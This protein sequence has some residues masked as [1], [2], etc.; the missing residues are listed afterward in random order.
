M[1]WFG[2]GSLD[3]LVRPDRDSVSQPTAARSPHAQPARVLPGSSNETPDKSASGTPRETRAERAERRKA[4]KEAARAKRLAAR[5][6][7]AS[8]A[9]ARRDARAAKHEA[10]HEQHAAAV[11]ARREAAE[12]RR[13][14]RAAKHEAARERYAAAVQARREAAEARREAVRQKREM[15]RAHREPA[16]GE[17]LER[18][19]L[20][21]S[22][23][24]DSGA[25]AIAG[26]AASGSGNAA[27]LRINSLPWAQVFIDGRMV[28]YTPQRGINLTPGDH[29]VRLI[30]PAFAMSK[31]LHV[32][33][34]QGQQ[35]TRNEI[36]E[37]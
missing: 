22:S 20:S 15:A 2:G 33:I 32:R 4:R 17:G 1:F 19:A 8:T 26:G 21:E 18:D 35:V 28:G 9:Q 27:I 24:L 12:A 13:D 3:L 30:N 11:Q 29:A 25:Y 6:L 16:G 37:E 34:A 31:T 10:A 7:R 5:E 36:L 23:S 14:A